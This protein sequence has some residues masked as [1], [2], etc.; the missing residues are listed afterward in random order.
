MN[1]VES[2]S[3]HKLFVFCLFEALHFKIRLNEQFKTA[4]DH[5]FLHNIYCKH[6]KYK[7]HK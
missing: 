4:K 5:N 2:L 1:I 7:N 6:L 3:I